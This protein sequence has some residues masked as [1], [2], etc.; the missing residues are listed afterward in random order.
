MR[1]KKSLGQHFLR[2]ENIAFNITKSLQ[3]TDNQQ[4]KVVEIGPGEGVLTKYLLERKEIEL[5]VVELDRR[6][7]AYLI[8][9]FPDLKHHFIQGDVL[10]IDFDL[11]FKD[12]IAVIGNFPYNISTQILFKILE[13]RAQVTQMVG[14]FQKEVA[15]RIAAQPHSKQY[16]VVSVLLQ[17]YYK[18]SYLFDVDKSCFDPPPRVQSGVVRLER[19]Q[20]DSTDVTYKQFAQV[21][22]K[23]FGQR[24]KKLSNALKGF[25]FDQTQLPENMMH[26]RAEQLSVAD[27]IQLAKAR[28]IS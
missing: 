2:E 11:L 12:K 18:A 1:K 3:T 5:F 13:H 6:L 28:I 7:P 10:K 27:F 8:K 21:V 23:A 19:I 4:N 17:R 9:K 25:T 20:E 26:Q 24:R 22:K 16:G 15:K 14:M